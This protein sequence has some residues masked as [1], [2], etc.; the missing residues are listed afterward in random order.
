MQLPSAGV[1]GVD[2][3]RA[4]REQHLRKPAGGRADI[5]TDTASGIEAEMVERC[6]EFDTR[7]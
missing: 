2:A 3:P 1:D 4:A 6:A 7:A 5:Q